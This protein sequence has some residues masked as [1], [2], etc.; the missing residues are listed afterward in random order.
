VLEGEVLYLA[1]S[2]SVLKSPSLLYLR[3]DLLAEFNRAV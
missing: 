3:D 2:K 1:W